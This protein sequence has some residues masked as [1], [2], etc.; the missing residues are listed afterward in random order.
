MTARQSFDASGYCSNKADKLTTV[1]DPFVVTARSSFCITGRKD[2]LTTTVSSNT[3]DSC[4]SS[5]EEKLFIFDGKNFAEWATYVEWGLVVHKLTSF[6]T[7]EAK[8]VNFIRAEDESTDAFVKY[9]EGNARAIMF[10]LERIS[11][12]IISR[13]MRCNTAFEIWRKLHSMYLIKTDIGED[14]AR[15]DLSNLYFS[16]D[17]DLEKF[18]SKFE[19]YV[20]MYLQCGGELS[21]QEELKIFKASLPSYF[22]SA[23]DWF[24]SLPCEQRTLENLK[25]K[26][27]DTH[28]AYKRDFK[29]TSFIG[30]VQHNLQSQKNGNNNIGNKRNNF[31]NNFNNNNNFNN[32]NRDMSKNYRSSNSN[33]NASFGNCNVW[34]F[35]PG[36]SL[37]PS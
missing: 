5:S 32:R 2:K 4:V 7:D 16:L 20:Q 36:Y 37:E 28:K 22:Q 30:S 26:V 1:L 33:N 13:V 10:L 19:K 11:S 14:A 31:R 34:W 3:M 24:H 21:A 12:N 29:S 23:K 9:Q 18:I 6:V 8:Y 35:W 17:G 27:I 25:I 15:R